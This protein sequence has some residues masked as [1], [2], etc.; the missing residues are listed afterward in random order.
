MTLLPFLGGF[1]ALLSGWALE[2]GAPVLFGGLV[3]MAFGIGT[4]LTRLFTRDQAIAKVVFEEL[5]QEVKKER[6]AHLDQLAQRLS[7]DS[8]PRDEKLLKDL[9]ELNDVF[10]TG[11]LWP[12]QSG[13]LAMMDIVAGVDE[14]FNK[15]VALL[16]RGHRMVEVANKMRTSA[17]QNTI[18]DERE[19]VLREVA[20]SLEQLTK[21][22]TGVQS[23]RST[24]G[25]QTEMQSV[26]DEL[27]RSLDLAAR[28]EERMSQWNSV[29][30]DLDRENP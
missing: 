23:L 24:E 4:A 6:D 13:G 19:I 14:L 12:D 30:H 10:K 11:N 27:N 15:C 3:G 8:D 9:R 20:T 17:A 5:Q 2:L 22:F 26:R 29:Q 1:T 16:E 21:V 7:Q 25:M 18:F 28:V